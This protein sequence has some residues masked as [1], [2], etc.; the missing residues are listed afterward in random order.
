MDIRIIRCWAM[1]PLFSLLLLAGCAFH[2]EHSWKGWTD[3][4]IRCTQISQVGV[5][6]K[7]TVLDHWM[8]HNALNVNL[9]VENIG[10]IDFILPKKNTEIRNFSAELLDSKMKVISFCGGVQIFDENDFELDLP[11]PDDYCLVHPGDSIELKS[12]YVA[13]FWP[14]VWDKEYDLH[15]FRVYYS[16][17]EP[18]IKIPE[19][20]K[21]KYMTILKKV[22]KEYCNSLRKDLVSDVVILDK[23]RYTAG[24]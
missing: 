1:S 9:R 13:P 2:Y 8:E 22:R 19:N 6:A 14:Y 11:S 5:E 4:T 10:K 15:S 21:E 20:Q 24:E 3:V 18:E 7:L 12:V 23:S 17:Y 16:F